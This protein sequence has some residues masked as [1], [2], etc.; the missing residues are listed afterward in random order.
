[1]PPQGLQGAQTVPAAAIKA[2]GLEQ[3][4]GA[5]GGQPANDGCAGRPPLAPVA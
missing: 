1:M 4:G 3:E 5:D 2:G